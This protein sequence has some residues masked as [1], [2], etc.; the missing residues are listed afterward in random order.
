MHLKDNFFY[1]NSNSPNL[2]VYNQIEDSI[3][4]P[5]AENPYFTENAIMSFYGRAIYNI[6]DKYVLNATLRRDGSYRFAKMIDG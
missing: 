6:N 4:Y 1:W 3:I 2:P 5:A